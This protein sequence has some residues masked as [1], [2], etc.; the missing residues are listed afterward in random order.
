M[1]DSLISADPNV[2]G[3][4]PAASGVSGPWYDSVVSSPGGHNFD[5]ISYHDY[6]GSTGVMLGG[7]DILWGVLSTYNMTYKP[8]W[9][10]EY[11]VSDSN[12]Q[13]TS[14]ISKFV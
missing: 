6:S 9:C 5:I 8:I 11:S 7:A 2:L 14:Q 4:L 13:D 3:V 1:T 12:V 10:G